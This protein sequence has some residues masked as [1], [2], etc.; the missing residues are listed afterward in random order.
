MTTSSQHR[1]QAASR[2]GGRQAT[3]TREGEAPS[4][5]KGWLRP[6]LKTLGSFWTKINNDWIMNLSGLLAYNFLMSIFPILLVL[7]AL[8][9]FVLNAISPGS[10]LQLERHI[11]T[12]LPG[13]AALFQAKT[14]AKL[15]Q[16][17][18]L[19]FLIGLV[20]SIITGSR[21][22]ITL[23]N[24]FGVIFRLRGRDVLH[25]N[26]MA[27]GMLFI[28]V[29]LVPIVFLASLLTTAIAQ[30]VFPGGSAGFGGF[31]IQLAGIGTGF[32][33]AVLLFGVIYVV[34]P[35][36]PVEW[37]EVWRG[38]LAAAA[39]FVVYEILFPIYESFFLKPGNYGSLAGFAIVILVFFFYLAFILLLGA[40]I[41]SWAAGQRQTAGDITALIHEVQAHNTTRGVAGP[42]AGTPRE[43]MQSHKGEEA[44]STPAKAVQHEREDHHTHAE[45]P[46]Y[47]E[48]GPGSGPEAAAPQTPQM[49]ERT[50]EAEREIER[51]HHGD[52]D[53][54]HGDQEAE[55]RGAAPTQPEASQEAG[56]PRHPIS[57]P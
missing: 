48:A 43:D 46:K 52:Q 26:M 37:R 30:L 16:S 18:G 45:P 35:N 38:T 2:A 40:E 9:G 41:N 36:R 20:T 5:L 3:T 23:E 21:L 47:A 49:D 55:V 28:Y 42:T 53:H 29:V 13:G 44:M 10:M 32:L 57:R 6:R 56:E 8:A 54:H 4:G 31:L 1:R 39:L 25:Q 14:L 19:V 27:I 11:G 15:G 51:H 24:C 17:A 22:F 33:V 34:V 12:A 7:L 50:H